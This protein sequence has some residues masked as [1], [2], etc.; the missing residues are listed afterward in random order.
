MGMPPRPRHPRWPCP[1]G[2]GAEALMAPLCTTVITRVA[3][4]DARHND[5]AEKSKRDLWMPFYKT[6][7]RTSDALA[8]ETCS[9]KLRRLDHE[10]IRSFPEGEYVVLA[11]AGWN[12]VCFAE[13]K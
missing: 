13:W 7:C 12:N 1:L 3:A 9:T 6:S 4:R 8:S 5:H 2:Q 11:G 10:R